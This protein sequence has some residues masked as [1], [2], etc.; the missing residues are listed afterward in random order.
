MEIKIDI[1]DGTSKTSLAFDRELEDGEIFF[2]VRN[3]EKL[4]PGIRSLADALAEKLTEIEALK[5]IEAEPTIEKD[6]RGRA[7]VPMTRPMT[8]T[9]VVEDRRQFWQ[10]RFQEAAQACNLDL[11][12]ALEVPQG[13]AS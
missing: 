5:V 12:P 1:T 6:E 11:G 13:V 9:S 10:R 3:W 2:S 4:S 8:A 7:Y